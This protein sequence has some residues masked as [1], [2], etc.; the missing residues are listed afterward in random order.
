MCAAPEANL[1]QKFTHVNFTQ[2]DI[3]YLFRTVSRRVTSTTLATFTTSTLKTINKGSFNL[4]N[5]VCGRND[6]EIL[7]NYFFFRWD[8]NIEGPSL[9]Q[10]FKI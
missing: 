7:K 4:G 1:C 9:H 5:L 2:T 3:E 6:S 10:N 8:G